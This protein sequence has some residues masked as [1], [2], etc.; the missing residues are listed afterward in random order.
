MK[1]KLHTFMH[2]TKNLYFGCTGDAKCD[3]MPWTIDTTQSFLDAFLAMFQMIEVHSI[4]KTK[5][6]FNSQS[7]RIVR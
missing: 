1:L 4:P 5:A 6:R 7:L 2:N 3:E